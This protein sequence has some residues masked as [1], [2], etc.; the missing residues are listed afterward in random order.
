R[1]VVRHIAPE[2]GVGLAVGH[3]P[4][5]ED[6]GA[7]APLRDEVHFAGGEARPLL[8]GDPP[9]AGQ[10]LGGPPGA[11]AGPLGRQAR[12]QP[13]PAGGGSSARPAA[14]RARVLSLPRASRAS[15]S[16]RPTVRPVTA[17]RTGACALPSLR[18]WASPAARTASFRD[19]AEDQSAASSFSRA[20][21]S[22]A[23]EPSFIALFQDASSKT[24]SGRNRKSTLSV[25]SE[26]TFRRVCACGATACHLAS[27]K[28]S[29]AQGA[30]GAF[31][32]GRQRSAKSF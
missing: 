14:T 31:S 32:H 19:S 12:P 27:S 13:L 4:P 30:C 26:S 7:V 29:G 1:L 21:R 5:Q 3:L 20:V 25:I 17:T 24:G 2:P 22:R 28:S 18:P 23:S 8:L 15:K 11:A 6:P 10:R 16:G 9:P